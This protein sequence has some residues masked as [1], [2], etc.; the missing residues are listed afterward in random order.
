[1]WVLGD[2]FE[3]V[4]AVSVSKNFRFVSTRMKYIQPWSNGEFP[5]VG[6]NKS[7][8][9][10]ANS[11]IYGYFDHNP[12]LDWGIRDPITWHLTFKLQT[13]RYKSHTRTK[14]KA[15]LTTRLIFTLLFASSHITPTKCEREVT[16]IYKFTSI[17]YS[18]QDTLLVRIAKNLEFIWFSL[19][20]T[21]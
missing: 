7:N 14:T 18:R 16:D 17:L 13:Y 3:F 6:N 4:C 9:T 5:L 21:H 19:K 10:H 2:L 11:W 1:M 12:F 15:Q 20:S 8:S